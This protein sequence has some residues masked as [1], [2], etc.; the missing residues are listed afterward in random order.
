MNLDPDLSPEE[1]KVFLEET[2]EQ[3]ELLDENIVKLEKEGDDPELLQ[4]IFRA[5]HTLK[6]SSAM[7]GHDR[8]AELT[9]AME[10]LLDRL[11]SHTLSVSTEIVDALLYGLDALK[12]LKEDITS[13]EESDLDITPI[14]AAIKAVTSDEAAGKAARKVELTV[15]QTVREDVQAAL[16]GGQSVFQVEV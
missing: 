8:M 9:H 1:L 13:P 5:A 10:S 3:I 16:A 2:E 15:D 6:G 11:R 7:V 14:V 4:E 12:V